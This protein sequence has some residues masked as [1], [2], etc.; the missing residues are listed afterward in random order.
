MVAVTNK[1]GEVVGY[2]G[3]GA[4][5]AKQAAEEVHGCC[6]GGCHEDEPSPGPTTTEELIAFMRDEF[7]EC[8]SLAEAK[9]SRYAKHTDPFKNL[10]RGGPFGIAVR[11]DDKVSRLLTLTSPGNTISGLDESIE[12]TCRDLINY[13]ALLMALRANQ[14]G[15]K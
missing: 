7:R 5:L 1:D 12:D 2:A 6:G 10:S 14:G 13:G 11:M 15:G 3:Y 8:L 9:N 4:A